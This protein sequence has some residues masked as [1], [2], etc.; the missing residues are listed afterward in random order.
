[1]KKYAIIINMTRRTVD[2][3]LMIG[4]P[5]LGFVGGMAVNAFTIAEKLAT[6]PYVDDKIVEARHY[7]DDKVANA[8][9]DAISHTDFNKE[10]LLLELERYNSTVKSIEVKIDLLQNSFDHAIK[11]K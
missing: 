8:L 11:R 3:I 5:A 2:N 4:L 6:K 1:M 9:K 7:T 10:Q